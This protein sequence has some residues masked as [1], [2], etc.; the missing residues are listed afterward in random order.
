MKNPVPRV[1]SP[2]Q[3]LC[4][5]YELVQR[6]RQREYSEDRIFADLLES[7]AN[8]YLGDAPHRDLVTLARSWPSP[9]RPPRGRV[10]VAA[11]R[12]PLKASAA[13]GSPAIH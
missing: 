12:R 6:F 10:P 11:Q 4:R 8:V 3:D 1:P 2:A 5:L 9:A 13:P 7:L